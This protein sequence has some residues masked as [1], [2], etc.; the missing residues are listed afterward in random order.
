MT[1]VAVI[2]VLIFAGYIFKN[3]A[4]RI[5]KTNRYGKEA[6]AFVSRIEKIAMH[7]NGTGYAAYAEFSTYRFYVTFRAENSILYEA[8]LLNPKK[9]LTTGSRIR[10]RYLNE[11]TDEA[12]LTE[13]IKA[14]P[15]KNLHSAF[16]QSEI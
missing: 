12:V 5:F 10:I 1:V 16:Q 7:A 11:Q 4:W 14:S 3:D 13:I 8:R 15:E 9:W 6:E 2:I